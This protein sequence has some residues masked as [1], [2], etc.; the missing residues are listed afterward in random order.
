MELS[1]NVLD[2]MEK[3]VPGTEVLPTGITASAS[4]F[5]GSPRHTAR[6]GSKR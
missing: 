1:E 4:A 5:Q 6:T 3:V 2:V